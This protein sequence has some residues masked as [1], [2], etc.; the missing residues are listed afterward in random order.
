MFKILMFLVVIG[1]VASEF[2]PRSDLDKLKD[3]KCNEKEWGIVQK[4]FELCDDA[5][6]DVST[7][8]TS[9]IFLHCSKKDG[10]EVK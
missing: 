10:V 9:S 8:Y 1:F 4:D 7:C 6:K 2:G 3:Y 5:A